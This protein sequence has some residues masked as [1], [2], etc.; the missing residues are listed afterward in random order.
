MKKEVVLSLHSTIYVRPEGHQK[1]STKWHRGCIRAAAHINQDRK[2]SV[3]TK[4]E[5]KKK[6]ALPLM[7]SALSYLGPMFKYKYGPTAGL[8]MKKYRQELFRSSGKYFSKLDGIYATVD[9]IKA[10]RYK[11]AVEWKSSSYINLTAGR[12]APEGRGC[13]PMKKAPRHYIG[14]LF[15]CRRLPLICY[16]HITACPGLRT[17]ICRRNRTGIRHC[18]IMGCPEP[19]RACPAR[20]TVS[21]CGCR[22]CVRC[23]ECYCGRPCDIG[24]THCQCGRGSSNIIIIHI[25]CLDCSGLVSV[26]NYRGRNHHHIMV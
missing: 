26:S 14:G 7:R 10:K 11:D 15:V 4:G 2:A 17:G 5:F 24:F 3:G 25:L 20:I 6:I 23:I 19:N 16:I 13:P 8:M 18:S 1:M 12:S 22:I 9:G 21:G